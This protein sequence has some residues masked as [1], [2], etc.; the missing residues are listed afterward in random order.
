MNYQSANV[1]ERKGQRLFAKFSMVLLA[2]SRTLRAIPIPLRRLI[3]DLSNPFGGNL[4]LAIRY[5]V[6]CSLCRSVGENVYIGQN[7]RIVNP[8]A[9][10]IG[11]NVSI[12]ASCYIDAVGGCEIGD[13]VSIA[14]ASS[15]LTFEHTW[16]NPQLPIKYNPT[17]NAAVS[18]K[19]DCWI[20]CGVRILSG[21]TIGTR[22]VVAAGAVVTR[23]VPHNAIAAGV[24]ARVIKFTD[25][26]FEK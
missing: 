14:H 4:A 7:V 18:I 19:S 22:C 15:I 20:G 3:W 6:L 1:N 9:L 23:N 11:D 16:E 12:H 26:G 5:I 17:I 10:T 13:N 21:V 25:S 24:P 8:E 2:L